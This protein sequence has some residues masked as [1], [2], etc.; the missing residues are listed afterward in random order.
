MRTKKKVAALFLL[1]LF[2]S[3]QVEAVFHF[4]LIPHVVCE[5]GKVVHHR[6][7][8]EHDRD[9]EDEDNPNHECCRF[10][11]LLTSAETQTSEDQSPSKVFLALEDKSHFF[12]NKI[13]IFYVDELFRLSP[14]NSPPDLT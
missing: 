1:T 12:Y 9:S 2:I 3:W 7:S 14:S 5:H 4:F 10:L 13:E 8:D 6:H 11:A